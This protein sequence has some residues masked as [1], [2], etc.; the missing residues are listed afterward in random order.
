MTLDQQRAIASKPLAAAI[1]SANPTCLYPWDTGHAV[2]EVQ[3]LLC[4]HGYRVKVDGDFGWLTEE[5]VRAFQRRQN[6]RVDGIVDPTTLA[7]LKATLQP[8]CRTLRPGHSGADVYVLQKV[9]NRLGNALTV[10]GVFG[11]KTAEAAIAFQAQ[12]SL[13]PNGTVCPRTWTALHKALNPDPQTAQPEQPRVKMHRLRRLVPAF[14]R[15]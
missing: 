12:N 15:V 11:E 3:E 7:T 8:G 10:D 14:G 4:A 1:V 2:A 6:L 5:A 9:L 13:T